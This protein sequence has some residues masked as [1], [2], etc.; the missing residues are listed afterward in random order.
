MEICN[1]AARKKR[2]GQ[3]VTMADLEAAIK[4]HRPS[5]LAY[6]VRQFEKWM[7]VS[8]SEGQEWKSPSDKYIT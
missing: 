6:L 7:G 5:I 1:R 8:R 3:P 2:W 4:A